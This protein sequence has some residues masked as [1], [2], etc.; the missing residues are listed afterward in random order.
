MIYTC[1]LTV[2]SSLDIRQLT[3][4][5]AS[6]YHTTKLAI[7]QIQSTDPPNIAQYSDWLFPSP[8]VQSTDPPSIALYSDW[9]FSSLTLSE[10]LDMVIL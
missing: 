1:M 2:G 10:R 6:C 7:P 9:P 4:L 5:E 8:Q 3:G